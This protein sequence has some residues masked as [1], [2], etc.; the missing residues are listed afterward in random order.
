M[1]KALSL[2][3]QNSARDN[4]NVRHRPNNPQPGHQKSGHHQH[5]QLVH[6]IHADTDPEPEFVNLSFST[7]NADGS[8]D[9]NDDDRDEVFAKLNIQMSS[10]PNSTAHIT[11]IVETGAQGN[12]LPIRIFRKVFPNHVD[13]EGYP[14]AG[15]LKSSKT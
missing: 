6:E 1:D 2:T 11:V 12:I 13:S 9:A 5:Q 10:A 8:S 7:I 15:T 4:K 14:C 3:C